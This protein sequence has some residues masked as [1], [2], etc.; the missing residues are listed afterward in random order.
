MKP[1]LHIQKLTTRLPK[2]LI[3]NHSLVN[4]YNTGS[5]VFFSITHNSAGCIE[6]KLSFRILVE[7]RKM[8][9]GQRGE[10]DT[11]SILHCAVESLILLSP[12]KLAVPAWAQQQVLR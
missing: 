9:N 10:K 7:E 6:G 4:N 8:V 3:E 12:P 1:F 11:L 5:Q 2:N